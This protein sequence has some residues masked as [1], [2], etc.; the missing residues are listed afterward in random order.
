MGKCRER[1]GERGAGIS[2]QRWSEGAEVSLVGG[3]RVIRTSQFSYVNITWQHNVWEG[4]WHL[5][6][7]DWVSSCFTD[8]LNPLHVYF[9]AVFNLFHIWKGFITCLF[10]VFN[11]KENMWTSPEIPFSRYN[12]NRYFLQQLYQGAKRK[13]EIP[14]TNA[15]L[16]KILLILFDTR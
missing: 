6:F 4:Q 10:E 15:T 11:D 12:A 13:G 5:I 3:W 16:W 1:R 14:Q 9:W 8:Y 2:Q 7:R